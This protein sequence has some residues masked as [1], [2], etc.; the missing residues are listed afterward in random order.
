MHEDDD[1]EDDDDDDHDHDTYLPPITTNQPH[2]SSSLTTNHTSFSFLL[3]LLFLFSVSSFLIFAYFLRFFSLARSVSLGNNGGA[4]S[5]NSMTG[6][7]M[8]VMDS[9]GNPLNNRVSG[10]TCACTCDA[11]A[12]TFT[13]PHTSKKTLTAATHHSHTLTPP[14]SPIH[15]G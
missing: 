11:P 12:T 2:F 13:H 6:G 10:G 3:F 9:D 14:H 15:Q 1:E 4:P 8:T 5:R 7:M